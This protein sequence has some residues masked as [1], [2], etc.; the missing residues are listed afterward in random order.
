MERLAADLIGAEV[1]VRS[2]DSGVHFGTLVAVSGTAV[3][4]KD[5]R[6]LYVWSTGGHGLSLSE[7][8]IFGI[9]HKESKI[10]E[11]LPD[12]I[13]AGVCEIIPCAGLAVATIRGA[14]TAKP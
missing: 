11:T 6:R 2:N 9:N 10:T 4:L 12:L 7:I 3:R 14:A 8:A 1:L 13:V 5:S